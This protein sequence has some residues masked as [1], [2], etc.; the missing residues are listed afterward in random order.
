VSGR[1]RVGWDG[2]LG[3]W[4]GGCIWVMAMVVG[5]ILNLFWV[6]LIWLDLLHGGSLFVSC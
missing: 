5:G 4:V 3:W 1:R 2:W 6:E